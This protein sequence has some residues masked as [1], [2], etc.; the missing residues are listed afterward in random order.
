MA[1]P[2]NDQIS[3]RKL[4]LVG[5]KS[6]A[7]SLPVSIIRLLGWQKGDSLF[8]RRQGNKIIIEKLED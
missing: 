6:F 5:G 8:V 3:T 7:V 1:R 4:N 2:D